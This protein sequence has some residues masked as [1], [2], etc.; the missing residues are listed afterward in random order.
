MN[1]FPIHKKHM[2]L[3]WFS[4][5]SSH[6]TFVYCP[7]KNESISGFLAAGRRSNASQR[8][9]VS[10]S[11]WNWLKKNHFCFVPKNY[12]KIRRIYGCNFAYFLIFEWKMRLFLVLKHYERGW[13]SKISCYRRLLN[14]LS[15]LKKFLSTLFKSLFGNLVLL[16]VR[17][18]VSYLST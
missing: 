6:W 17:Y 14:L 18:E 2:F 15:S 5:F 16:K 1:V 7:Q 13:K 8:N 3:T 10:H 9:D 12:W 11:V 4:S